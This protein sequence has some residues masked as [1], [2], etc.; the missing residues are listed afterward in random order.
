MNE[1][2]EEEEDPGCCLAI[3]ASDPSHVIIISV[4]VEAIS[5]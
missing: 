5:E 3:P 2:D 1:E 4:F